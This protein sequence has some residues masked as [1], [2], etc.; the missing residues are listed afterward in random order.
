MEKDEVIADEIINTKLK[1]KGSFWDI[2]YEDLR[3]IPKTFV[4]KLINVKDNVLNQKKK[5]QKKNEKKD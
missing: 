3:L 4:I 1:V 5:K 2:S